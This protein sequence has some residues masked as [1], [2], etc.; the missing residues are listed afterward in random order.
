MYANVFGSAQ[1]AASVSTPKTVAEA[2]TCMGMQRPRVPI[3]IRVDIPVEVI[4]DVDYLRGRNGET[5]PGC[6]ARLVAYGVKTLGQFDDRAK[7]QDVIDRWGE[8]T[9]RMVKK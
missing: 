9:R 4:A 8:S 7:Y 3:R 2:D 1:G 5:R 6:I